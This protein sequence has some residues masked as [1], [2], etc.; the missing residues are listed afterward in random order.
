MKFPG[1]LRDVT[2]RGDRREHIFL[3]DVDRRDWLDILCASCQ[4][5]NWVVHVF[6]QTTN[7]HHLF[8]FVSGREQ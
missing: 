2:S 8:Y 7:H 6:C 1:A 5:F 3:N 4:R